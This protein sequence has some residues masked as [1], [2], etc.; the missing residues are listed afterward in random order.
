MGCQF[1]CGI[2]VEKN[3]TEVFLSSDTQRHNL[4]GQNETQTFYSPQKIDV[5][6]MYSIRLSYL[7]LCVV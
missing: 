3:I 6:Y 1:P 5:G 2:E 4:G 7:Y